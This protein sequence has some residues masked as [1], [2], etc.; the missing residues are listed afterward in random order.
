MLSRPDRLAPISFSRVRLK[1]KSTNSAKYLR[2]NGW[3]SPRTSQ[4][5]CHFLRVLMVDGS[6]AKFYAPMEDLPDALTLQ[7]CPG[8]L[9]RFVSRDLIQLHRKFDRKGE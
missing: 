8:S 7:H 2:S 1:R 3:A 5:L 6:T 9:G 4:T